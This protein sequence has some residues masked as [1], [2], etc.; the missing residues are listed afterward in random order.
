MVTVY[1]R[2][3]PTFSADSSQSV[4]KTVTDTYKG[5]A[6]T[7]TRSLIGRLKAESYVL[8]A[9]SGSHQVLLDFVAPEYGFD[10]W[11]GSTHEHQDG[12]YTGGAS[13][14]DLANNKF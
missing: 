12:H 10:V 11:V 2:L 14:Q 7:Y 4:V 13:S 6:Y 3:L 1:E 5:Q 9:I 8:I